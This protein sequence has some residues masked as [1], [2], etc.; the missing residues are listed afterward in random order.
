MSSQDQSSGLTGLAEL[1]VC[2]VGGTRYSNPLNPTLDSKWRAIHTLGITIFIVGFAN[3]LRPRRFR[4]Q[5]RF[6]LLPELPTSILRYVEMFLLVPPLLLWLIFRHDVSVMVAQ[7]PF[8]GV[9]GAL[10]KQI[11]RLFGKQVSLAIESHGDFEVAVFGQRQIAFA[12]AYRWFMKRAARYSLRHADALRAVSGSSRQ[13]LEQWMPGTPVIQFM[14]WIDFEAFGTVNR[15]Q[16]L[17]QSWDLVC[18]AVLVPRKGQH[19]LIEAFAQVADEF[20]AAKVWL[21]GK[22]ENLEYATQLKAQVERLGL[23]NRVIFVGAVAQAELAG[24][25]GRARALVLD[26]TSEGLPRVVMEA[27]NGGLVPV[28]SAVSGTPEVIEDG[29]TGYLISPEDVPALVKALQTMYRDPDIDAMGARAQAFARQF[30]S[31][32]AYVDGYRRLLETALDPTPNPSPNS[33][34][35]VNASLKG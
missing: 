24:Y 23:A 34:R 20:P 9:A 2:W 18:A 10:A 22:A 33:G 6:Y 19:I 5:A 7:S 29:V 8:E 12:G 25:M 28:A 13:Q 16:P 4:Q 14:T 21:L 1:K 27:M 11:A 31:Q 3:G 30:F 35:E 15:E 32:A 26:S 17:S